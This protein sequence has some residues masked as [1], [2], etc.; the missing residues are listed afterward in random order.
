MGRNVLWRREV[1]VLSAAFPAG[2]NLFSTI[3][4]IRFLGL[5]QYG[6]WLIWRTA[7]QLTSNIGPG[8]GVALSVLL[9]KHLCNDKK[10]TLLHCIAQKY[11][12]FWGGV[13]ASLAAIFIF[14]V[15][16]ASFLVSLFLVLFWAGLYFSGFTGAIARGY[17][18]GKS[19]LLGSAA[20]SCGSILS[21]A[22]AFY[23]DFSI[24]VAM[25]AFRMWAKAFVQYSAPLIRLDIVKNCYRTLYLR[26]ILR[27]GLPLV[28]RGWVQTSLQ[29]GDRYLI[30]TLFGPVVGSIAGLG[31]MMAMPTVIVASSSAAWLLPVL[32]AEP[33]EGGRVS[34]VRE[35]SLLLLF[36]FLFSFYIPLLPHFVPDVA[37]NIELVT[38]V[39]FEA[40]LLSVVAPILSA[41]VACG[42]FWYAVFVNFSI[43]VIVVSG[44]LLPY[45]K[46]VSLNNSFFLIMVLVSLYIVYISFKVYGSKKNTIELGFSLFFYVIVS[47]FCSQSMEILLKNQEFA[48]FLAFI[49]AVLVVL[50]CFY[51]KK[52]IVVR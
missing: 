34:V 22:A 8:F 25:Q 52:R 29:Y 42:Q 47:F 31:A 5:E 12:L 45:M 3:F 36:V 2:V 48:F 15:V 39:Y 10:I 38:T 37:G 30:G 46:I 1:L 13:A 27:A 14:L 49:S 16:D 40:C 32:L 33:K 44:L 43:A 17:R 41:I 28:A 20:D 51:C 6:I 24:F 50:V 11:A 35:I 21:V 26:R 19:I 7:C 18:D 23:G 9:P 4:V